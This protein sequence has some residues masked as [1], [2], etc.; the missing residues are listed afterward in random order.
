MVTLAELT[1]LNVVT[2]VLLAMI[3]CNAVLLPIAP[4][5]LR[6]DAPALAVRS[7]LPS[8][9]ELKVMPLP[10]KVGLLAIVIASL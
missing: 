3:F 8:K 9:V 5:K 1:L 6:F 4:L 7:L 10:V 2:P